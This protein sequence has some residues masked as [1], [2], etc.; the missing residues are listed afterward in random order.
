MGCVAEKVV[1]LCLMNLNHVAVFAGEVFC[2]CVS[3]KLR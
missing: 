1:E 2:L 3:A